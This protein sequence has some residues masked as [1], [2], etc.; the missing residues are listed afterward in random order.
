[1]LKLMAKKIFAI[2]GTNILLI[3]TCALCMLGNCS[4]FFFQNLL[5]RKILL[6]ISGSNTFDTLMVFLKIFFEKVNFE[7]S[8]NTTT[9]A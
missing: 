4:C 5:F 3:K 1:M 2:L 7:K 6:G 8:Q 9:K